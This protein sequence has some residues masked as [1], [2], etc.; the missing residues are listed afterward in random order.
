VPDVS[1]KPAQDVFK[2]CFCI[3]VSK[4]SK[5]PDILLWDFEEVNGGFGGH[6]G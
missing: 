4:Y 6:T 1:L 2:V 3:F 5:D